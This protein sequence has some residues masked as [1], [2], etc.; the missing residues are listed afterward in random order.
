MTKLF[1]IMAATVTNTDTN[2]NVTFSLLSGY[3]KNKQPSLKI[4]TT[5]RKN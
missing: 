4:M 5:N 1:D 2:K 3:L